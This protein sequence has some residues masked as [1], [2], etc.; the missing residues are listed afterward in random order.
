[1]AAATEAIGRPARV[2]VIASWTGGH[3][4]LLRQSLRMTNESFAEYLGVAVRTV[5][6]W[7]KRRDTIPRPVM[8]E[9]LDAALERAPERAKA[10]FTVLVGQAES[11]IRSD[12][13]EVLELPGGALL[14]ASA[15][16][17]PEFGDSEYLQSIRRH[18]REIVALDNRFGGADLVQLSRRFFR[19]LHQQLGTGTY[20]LKLERDLQSAAAELAEVVGWLAYD[21]EAHDLVRQMNQESLYF[22]R[23]G[24]DKTIELLTLQNSSMHAASQGRPKEALQ[25]ARS[26]LEGDYRLSPRLKALFLTRKARALAQ[27]G[28]DSALCLLPEI[29]FLYLEGVSDQDPAWAWWIDERELAWHEAMVQRDLG[30]PERAIAQFERSVMATPPTEIRSQY[31]HCAYLLQG[32]VDNAIWDD[33]EQSI[34]QLLPLSAEVAS[35]RTVILLRKV[36]SQVAAHPRVPP[37]LREQITVLNTALDQAPV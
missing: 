25:I 30:M 27:G 17:S 4:D 1:M 37:A 24:G 7:R 28:D 19:T 18:I 36:V 9:T 11:D 20:D 33:A 15:D 2:Q 10:Q 5:A 31:L 16:A 26:V 29:R 32:Q 6:Y 34:R 14:G 13:V 3:A 35:T 22:A 8:Q 21:A 12:H 23:L